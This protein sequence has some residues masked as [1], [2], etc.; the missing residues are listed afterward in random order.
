MERGAGILMPISALPCKYGIGSLGEGAYR[1]VDFLKAAG[2]KYWQVLPV[3][4]TGYG[5]SPYQTCADNSGNPYFIDLEIL[6]KEGLLTK[7]EVQA[8]AEKSALID[9]GKLYRERYPLLRK[10]FSRFD[11]KTPDFVRWCKE[12]KYADY[13]CFMALRQ[14]YVELKNFPAEYKLR[15]EK[16]ISDFAK[17]NET[18]ILF[19]QFLQYQFSRQWTAL[20]KYVNSKGIKI[21][22]DQPLYVAA[23]SVDGGP[24]PSSSCSTRTLRPRRWQASRPTTFRRTDSFGV[25]PSTTTSDMPRTASNG[26]KAA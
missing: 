15:D 14:K 4:Q 25:T 18:E 17:E 5:D 21:I 3:V 1:F 11:V 2:Q 6:F 7:R 12:G 22:G 26:G 10:A 20:K 9:Y 8:S 23:D 13:A 24:N 16:A 19:W